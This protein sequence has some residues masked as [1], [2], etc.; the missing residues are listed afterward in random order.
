M[1]QYY[2]EKLNACALD[3]CLLRAMD[4]IGWRDKP[5][6]VDL[7]DRRAR[8]G[9]RAHHAGS[10]ISNV[11]IAGI[12][13][14]LEEDG[15]ITIGTGATDNGMGVDTI[16]AQIA[17]EELGVES[18]LIVV[19]GVDTDVSPFDA[20]SYASSGTY[21]T[22]LAAKNA[23]T[24]LRE[25]ICAKRPDVD[26]DAADVVF[27][28][29]YV[30][31]S[32]ERAAREQNRYLT[33]GD[34]ANLCVKNIAGG[35]ALTSHA[36]ACLPVSPPPFMAGIAEVEVDK[37]TGKVTVVDYAAAVDCGTVINEALARVQA[38]G[39]IAQGIG[40]AL[41]EI[42]EHD[43][44]GRLRTGNFMSYKLPTRLDI[45]SI[46]V[47]FEPSYEPTG[48]FGAKSIGEVVINTPLA[49]VASAVAHA[50][51]HQV[52]SLPIT[53]EKALLGE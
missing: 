13:M 43:D 11:D 33:L 40:H 3:R 52:R 23:A 45:G 21:V 31:L 18:S 46:R 47:A 1:P 9:L 2:N 44:R 19:R 32:D 38:E 24:E 4:M 8:P 49:A 6:A 29:Q 39:G 41:Y 16:L 5:L 17:A 35:D 34:F 53:P 42:V 27:D 25:K 22:G 48:P 51:G 14:R 37:A 36:S 15:F 12:D 50:T 26:V 10:G 7:G 28:G 30:R 20:G